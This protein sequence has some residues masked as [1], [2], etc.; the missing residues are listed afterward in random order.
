MLMLCALGSHA[1]SG[2]GLMGPATLA[3]RH[4]RKVA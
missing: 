2:L 4:M 1:R 3:G